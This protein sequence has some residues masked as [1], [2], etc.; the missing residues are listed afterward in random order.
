[1]LLAAACRPS[2]NPAS[3]ACRAHGW[4]SQQVSLSVCRKRPPPNE[5]AILSLD[6]VSGHSIHTP[7]EYN[8]LRCYNHSPGLGHLFTVQPYPHSNARMATCRMNRCI[9]TIEP[10][11][12]VCVNPVWA[13]AFCTEQPVPLLTRLI[14]SATCC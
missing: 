13:L 10:D 5:Q 9:S 7:L 2:Y 1:M 11:R 12:N 6:L 3:G 4:V 8:E 14:E